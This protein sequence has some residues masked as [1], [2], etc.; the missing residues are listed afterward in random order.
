MWAVTA[1]GKRAPVDAAPVHP[2]AN[3]LGTTVFLSTGEGID[4]SWAGVLEK[5]GREDFVGAIFYGKGTLYE[6]LA[7]PEDVRVSHWGTCPQADEHR[8]TRAGSPQG[9]RSR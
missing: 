4:E 7:G 9:W 8:D 2:S 3:R 5:H 6:P 1:K